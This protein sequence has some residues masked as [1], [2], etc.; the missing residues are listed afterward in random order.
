MYGLLNIYICMYL[1]MDKSDSILEICSFI[2]VC[3]LVI[4]FM[5]ISLL[6]CFCLCAYL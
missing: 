4:V 1:C 2:L 6:L 3:V 5:Y